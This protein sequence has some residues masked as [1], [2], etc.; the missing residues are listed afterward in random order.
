M[1]VYACARVR[2]CVRVFVMGLEDPRILC[3]TLA[4]TKRIILFSF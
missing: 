4:L 1:C 3:F 2:V